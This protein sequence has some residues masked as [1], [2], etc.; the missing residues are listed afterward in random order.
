M[1]TGPAPKATLEKKSSLICDSHRASRADN[2]MKAHKQYSLGEVEL[3][4]CNVIEELVQPGIVLSIIMGT[5]EKDCVLPFG[6]ASDLVEICFP[7][8]GDTDLKRQE[9]PLLPPRAT[10]AIDT[11]QTNSV[12]IGVEADIR[13][14]LRFD[15]GEPV[16]MV[17]I[18]L[19][20][21]LVSLQ[22][23]LGE[24]LETPVFHSTTPGVLRQS[25][26][27]QASLRRLCQVSA[28]GELAAMYRKSLVLELLYLLAQLAG[29]SSGC[30][31]A[32]GEK[33]RGQVYMARS[34]LDAN[35]A[36]PPGLPELT[37]LCGLNEYQLKKGFKKFF[38]ETV[39]GYIT[40]QRME[41]ARELLADGYTNVNEAGIA[42][43]YTNISHFIGV[44]QKYFGVT[45][46]SYKR[47]QVARMERLQ[48]A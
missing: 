25:P 1:K 45:P 34:I 9:R 29:E 3:Q 38:G 41:R 10:N 33:D 13:G 7:V 35:I 20:P 11:K 30:G 42:V 19:L 26:A 47:D 39:F 15:A 2:A 5:P 46:G 44:F 28:S 48:G 18:R 17:V 31:K 8:A 23:G 37:H 12:F 14:T 40:Q 16:R 24:A 32:D 6:Q 22:T 27:M 43:G 4:G 21:K 36:E